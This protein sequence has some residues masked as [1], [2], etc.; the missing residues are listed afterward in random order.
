MSTES[1]S[2]SPLSPPESSLMVNA[3]SQ[4]GTSD[5]LNTERSG[6]EISTAKTSNEIMNPWSLGKR[7]MLAMVIGILIYSVLIYFVDGSLA[8]NFHGSYTLFNELF[9]GSLYLTWANILLGL[10]IVVPFFFATK[11]GPWVGLACLLFGALIGDSFLEQL[12]TSHFPGM[13]LPV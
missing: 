12:P 2:S 7:Q 11:F 6:T 3:Q 1:P 4:T 13:T 8:A 5:S 9:P 10:I